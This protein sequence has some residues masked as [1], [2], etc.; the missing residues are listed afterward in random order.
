L[1]FYNKFGN[2]LVL[3]VRK[4]K[5]KKMKFTKTRNS[6][7]FKQ[8]TMMGHE[9]C[10]D[11]I[12]LA[13]EILTKYVKT[14]RT[15]ALANY[16]VKDIPE[17]HYW[18]SISK[19]ELNLL[20]FVLRRLDKAFN[21]DGG[22]TNLLGMYQNRAGCLKG[23]LDWI[24][25]HLAYTHDKSARIEDYTRNMGVWGLTKKEATNRLTEYQ[26]NLIN[27]YEVELA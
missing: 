22:L 14:K 8:P 26:T 11:T 25:E 12:Y 3:R 17:W 1:T 19:K 2:V 4:T 13:E 18:N 24:L 10:K 7:W 20:R 27:K 6:D 5:E 9:W 23:R 16:V 21:S 15:K